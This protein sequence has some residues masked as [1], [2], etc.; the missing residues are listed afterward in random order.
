MTDIV[1]VTP[2]P[3]DDLSTAVE[4][5]VRSPS[6][7]APRSGATPAAAASTSHQGREL[8]AVGAAA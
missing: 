5:I 8:T 1:T 3:A 4:R 6:F 7:A 2:D